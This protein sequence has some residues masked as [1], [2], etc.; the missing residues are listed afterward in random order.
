MGMRAPS[1]VRALAPALLPLATLLAVAADARATELADGDDFGVKLRDDALVCLHT[2]LQ[3]NP[4]PACAEFGTPAPARA[5]DGPIRTLASGI[6]R[7]QDGDG[8]RRALAIVVLVR[9]KIPLVVEPETSADATEYAREYAQGVAKTLAPA[10]LRKGSPTA[11]V[12]R[13]NGIPLVRFAFDLDGLPE[14]RRMMEHHVAFA[15]AAD[16]ARY[17]I[18]FASRL[19]DADVVDTFA[20]D[21]IASIRLPRRAPTRSRLVGSWATRILLAGGSVG[22]AATVAILLV[23]RGRRRAR[24]AQR[25]AEAS[26]Q[27]RNPVE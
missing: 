18:V 24:V 5:S 20:G 13:V 16:G 26:A 4:D 19:A 2:P 8:G 6:V 21:S 27:H 23:R 1:F 12:W 15:A 9:A 11:E 14:D 22:A 10:R 25:A 17:S 7:L 3:A